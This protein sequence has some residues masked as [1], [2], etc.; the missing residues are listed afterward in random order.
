[1]NKKSIILRFD[2]DRCP[3]GLPIPT[4]CFYAGDA[5]YKMEIGQ[6]K[7]N[8]TL[9]NLERTHT[10]CPYAAQIIAERQSVNC[11][12]L[13]APGIQVVPKMYRGQFYY[14]RLWEGFNTVNLDRSYHQYADFNYMSFNY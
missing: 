3:F 10:Q 8:I 4:A 13:D 5:A 11:M 2:V 1:M 6:T 7:Q 14:P 12:A 9:Y